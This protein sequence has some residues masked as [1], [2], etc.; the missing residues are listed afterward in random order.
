MVSGGSALFDQPGNAIGEGSCLSASRSGNNQERTTA[1]DNSLELGRVQNS[2]V[3]NP[4][5]GS[6]GISGWI[7]SEV[8]KDR[9]LG[10]SYTTI[11]RKSPLK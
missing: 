1:M 10:A 5:Q 6:S 4:A 9:F 3:V 11:D 8:R 7:N 2:I